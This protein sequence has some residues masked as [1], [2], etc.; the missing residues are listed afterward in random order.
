MIPEESAED[1]LTA[2]K[3]KSKTSQPV[4]SSSG[5]ADPGVA[6]QPIKILKSESTFAKSFGQRGQNKGKKIIFAD[7]NGENIAENVYVEQLH[8]ST[9]SYTSTELPK[10]CCLV[11]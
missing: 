7:E 9:S 6:P 3:R 2:N 11:S 4:D 5:R 8:Y 10:G 1:T